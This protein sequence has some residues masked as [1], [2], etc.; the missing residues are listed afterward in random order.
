VKKFVGHFDLDQ[1][2]YFLSATRKIFFFS[3]VRVCRNMECKIWKVGIQYL[4][5][6]KNLDNMHTT[7]LKE[8]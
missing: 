4:I 5:H 6:A 8:F 2:L 7:L 3:V 1:G